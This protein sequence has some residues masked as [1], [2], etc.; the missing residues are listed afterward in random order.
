MKLLKEKGVL[1][2]VLISHDAGW[3][4]P[5]KDNGGDFRGYSTLF[6]KLIP[7]M[8]QAGFTGEEIEQVFITNP[9]AAYAVRI[10]KL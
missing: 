8:K 4:D 5:A 2:K 6:L 10:R 1:N 7:M 3:Y 9:S